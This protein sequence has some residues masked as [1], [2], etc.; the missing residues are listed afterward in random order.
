MTTMTFTAFD[1][2][3]AFV[4]E[5]VQAYPAIDAFEARMGAM[6]DR[7][8]L[9]AAAR[10]LACPVKAHPPNWQHGRVLYV[11]AR[12]A[13][14]SA[15]YAQAPPSP[16]LLLDIGSAK[17]FSALVLQWALRDAGIPGRVVSLDV[18]DPLARVRRNTVAEVD[19]YLTLAET[20][21]PWREAQSIEFVQSD[22]RAWLAAH[23]DR[24][25]VAYVDG[26]H[27]YEAVSEDVDL[28]AGR[29][30]AGDVVVCDDLQIPGVAK[31]VRELAGYEVEHLAA[32]PERAYAIAR[33]R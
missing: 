13:L 8:Q 21:A 29:Q 28:L 2:D 5:Q 9:E 11:A 20:L 19:G 31:A 23:T 6:V 26:K 25:H 14:T 27:T 10:V 24:V 33:R 32:K 12:H 3:A 7:G 17:G 30:R 15:I 4:A 16:V 22:S 18:I 1:Y